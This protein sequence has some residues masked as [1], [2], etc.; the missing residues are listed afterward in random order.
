[1]DLTAVVRDFD[2]DGGGR[3]DKKRGIWGISAGV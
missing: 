1:M 3:K 2:D